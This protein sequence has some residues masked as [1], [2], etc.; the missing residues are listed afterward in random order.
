MTLLPALSSFALWPREDTSVSGL[1][2]MLFVLFQVVEF[3]NASTHNREA[4]NLQNQVCSLRS[5]WD[6][7][8]GSSDL[9]HSLPMSGVE[10]PPPPTF[11]LMQA[12]DKVLCLVMDVS[13]KMAEVTHWFLR[14]ENHSLASP[15]KFSSVL[16]QCMKQEGTKGFQESK[17]SYFL[18]KWVG[19]TQNEAQKLW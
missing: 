12:G 8:T 10:L 17:V 5:T 19:Q 14:T 11:S 1:G 16:F 9:N 18:G 6:I 7:I 13:R 4:P 3:C 2:R 15:I